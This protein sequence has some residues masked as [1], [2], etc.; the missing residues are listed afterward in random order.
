MNKT[1]LLALLICIAPLLIFA[2]DNDITITGKVTDENN[3]P[4]PG[5]NIFIKNTST[6][7]ISEFDG[8]Y[9]IAIPSDAMFIVF[10]YIG[11][12]TIEEPIN[13]RNVFTASTLDMVA[14]MIPP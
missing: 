3:D 7:T 14:I 8:S 6:G 9:A 1:L 12:L 2:Q 10:P 13:N 4:I 11:F 5:V